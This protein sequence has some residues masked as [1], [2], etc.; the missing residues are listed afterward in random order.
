MSQPTKSTLLNFMRAQ[1]LISSN[2][3]CIILRTTKN[4]YPVAPR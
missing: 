1:T 2:K 4:V 3:N